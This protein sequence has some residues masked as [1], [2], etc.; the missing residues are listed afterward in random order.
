MWIE[1]L[2]AG[3]LA[4]SA[5]SPADDA[6][7][8]TTPYFQTLG[9][10]AGM[11]S[12]RIYKTVQDR[13]GYLWFGTQDGLARYDGVGFRVYRHDPKDPDSLGG[14]AVTALFVDRDNRIWC[15]GEESGLNMLDA[16][17]TASPLS[18]RCARS[19]QPRRRRRMDDHPGRVRCGLDWQLRGRSGPAQAR[20]GRIRALPSRFHKSTKH[21]LGQRARTAVAA[22]RRIVG[23]Q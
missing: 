5:A 4:A 17:A 9:V 14:N 21:F 3:A 11:P 20:C 6:Q 1:V 10:A 2:L 23:W 22:R 12:S 16:A 15:G 13:D 18:A 8:Y 19:I 7:L